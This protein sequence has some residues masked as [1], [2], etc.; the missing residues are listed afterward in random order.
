MHYLY[1]ITNL[2]DGK[3][4]I[5][6]SIKENERWRQHRY[7]GRNPEWT[8][9]YLHYA[10]N[11]H[12]VENFVYEVIAMS[13]KQDDADDLEKLLIR[14]YDSRNREK[15]YNISPGGDAAWN[16][17]LPKEKQPM[18]G[19]KQSAYF[20]KKMSEIHSGKI[21]SH[22]EETRKKI[23]MAGRGKPKSEEWKAK[24]S[25]ENHPSSKLTWNIVNDIRREYL[26]GASQSSLAIKYNVTKTTIHEIVK[27]K[28]WK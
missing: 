20:K 10:M 11:K 9:Q 23:S 2:L 3:V 1:K 24:H 7:F 18:F 22:S 19:K 17:G 14:Q 16:R 12:G 13:T 5:G 26:S 4:Y 8:K 27:G 28:T 6:R 25:G 15:G 21:V